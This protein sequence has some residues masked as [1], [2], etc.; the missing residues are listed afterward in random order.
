M[1]PY[2]ILLLPTILIFSACQNLSH[3]SSRETLPEPAQPAGQAYQC[4]DL[5]I[6]ALA[7]GDMMILV[8]PRGDLRLAPV[9]AASGARYAD[10]VGNEFWDKG[11]K[12]AL[13]SL[14]GGASLECKGTE[15]PSPWAEARRRGVRFRGVGQEPGWVVELDRG[16]AAGMRLLLDYGRHELRFPTTRQIRDEMS[17]TQYFIGETNQ[18]RAELRVRRE[19]CR[20]T[21]S[22]ELFQTS[23]ELRINAETLR[24]CGRYFS[25]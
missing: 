12:E 2:P 9:V 21:M 13:L 24:G 25:D 17:D 5:R 16:E 18:T 4:G 1:R 23:A 15:A 20:D 22:G 7:D 3:H 11:Q 14:E 10:E 8:L 6:A 19:P